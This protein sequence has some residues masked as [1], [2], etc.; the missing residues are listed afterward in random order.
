M[1]F[2]L[3]STDTQVI[4]W[5]MDKQKKKKTAVSIGY[6]LILNSIKLFL[7]L[8]NEIHRRAYMVAC[9]LQRESSIVQFGDINLLV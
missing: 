5:S 4:A 9:N 8:F 1:T 6:S 7:L 3:T 2:I